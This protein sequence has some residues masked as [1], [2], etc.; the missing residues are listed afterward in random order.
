MG[1]DRDRGGA[2]RENS[3]GGRADERDDVQ[4]D[5]ATEAGIVKVDGDGD[6]GRARRGVS[7]ASILAVIDVVSARAPDIPARPVT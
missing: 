1:T 3:R 2:R 6:R 4:D 5:G 7:S